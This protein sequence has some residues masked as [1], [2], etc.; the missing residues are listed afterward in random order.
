MG[1]QSHRSAW[2]RSQSRVNIHHQMDR[3]TSIIQSFSLSHLVGPKLTKQSD[4]PCH[5]SSLKSPIPLQISDVG[6]VSFGRFD[7]SDGCSLYKNRASIWATSLPY[8]KVHLLIMIEAKIDLLEFEFKRLLQI[9]I[10]INSNSS[11]TKTFMKKKILIDA[12]A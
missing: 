12:H 5:Q 9:E 2:A 4:S 8:K 1:Y 11:R 6:N 7:Y 10:R 3:I